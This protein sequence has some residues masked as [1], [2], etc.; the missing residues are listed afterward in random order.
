QSPPGV[1]ISN[2]YYGEGSDL[3][4]WEWGNVH[5]IWLGL[6][7]FYGGYNDTNRNDVDWGKVRWLE[8]H[9]KTIG[10]DKAILF[11]QHFGWEY[12]SLGE[13]DHSGGANWWSTNNINLLGD[14]ICDRS[15]KVDDNTT[16][17]N[18][19]NVI[20]IFS[21]HLHGWSYNPPLCVIG[22]YHP[23]DKVANRHWKECQQTLDIVNYTV[24]DGGHEDNGGYYMV[25]L[26]IDKT[27]D[28]STTLAE[29][30][31]TVNKVAISFGDD[32]SNDSGDCNNY[33]HFS[34]TINDSGWPKIKKFTTEIQFFQQGEPNNA[35][36]VEHCAEVNP[37]GRANDVKCSLEKRVACKNGQ[38]WALS[39]EWHYT[40]RESFATCRDMG[41]GWEFA[42][43][44]TIEDQKAII[45]LMD[46][47]HSHNVWVNNTDKGRHGQWIEAPW[48]YEF[49]PDNEP[50]HGSGDFEQGWGQN[51]GMIMPDTQL[52]HDQYC[53][54]KL[55]YCL[56]KTSA[57]WRVADTQSRLGATWAGCFSECADN[58]S[59][60]FPEDLDDFHK[61]QETVRDWGLDGKIWIG[62]SD[63]DEEGQ[64]VTG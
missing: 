53:E 16:C 43:P 20:G 45:E 56:C 37:N 4:A 9:L 59:F 58:E 22:E 26:Q 6:W 47:T 61:L 15:A 10:K 50:N 52:L 60:E 33:Q 62:V 38:E 23:D 3:Y 54:M 29:G 44:K 42:V 64:W 41:A 55:D 8:D 5:F 46:D 28:G 63:L 27:E 51:C 12:L 57:G 1:E 35:G 48:F 18:P 40:W 31:M 24:D 34:K 11:F 7:A 17:D 19:Y 32:Y 13:S 49:F 36:G 2:Y 14:V 39:S 25:R 21:G 30:T